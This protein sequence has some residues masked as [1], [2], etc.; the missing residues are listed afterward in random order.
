MYQSEN[1]KKNNNNK[2]YTA[3]STIRQLGPLC[4]H[5]LPKTALSLSPWFAMGGKKGEKKKHEN[6]IRLDTNH[7]KS[8]FPTTWT[9]KFSYINIYGIQINVL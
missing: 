8:F 3:L 1:K 2:N 6:W 7:F 4:G 5:T 9:H